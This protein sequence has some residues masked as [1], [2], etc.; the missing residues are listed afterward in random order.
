MTYRFIPTKPECVIVETVERQAKMV[1][2]NFILFL[3]FG[4]K[5]DNKITA[6]VHGVW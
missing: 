1:S 2:V 6:S 5:C 3:S 4:L